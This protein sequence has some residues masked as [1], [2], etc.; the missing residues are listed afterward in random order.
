MKIYFLSL[1]FS[2]SALSGLNLSIEEPADIIKISSALQT[3]EINYSHDTNFSELE[4][5][6][7]LEAVKKI[8][9][10]VVSQF[11]NRLIHNLALAM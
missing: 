5:K 10:Q 1:S 2:L 9:S 6:Y 7:L 4:E 8:K 11:S 3:I